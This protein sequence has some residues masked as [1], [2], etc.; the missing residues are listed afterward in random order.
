[1]TEPLTGS[2]LESSF[3]KLPAQ[4]G[5]RFP[6]GTRAAGS[7]RAAETGKLHFAQSHTSSTDP[8]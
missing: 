6:D 3:Q 4:Q 1:M 2:S 8:N 7:S 5:A